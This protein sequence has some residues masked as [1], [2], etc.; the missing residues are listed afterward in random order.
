MI[1]V[2]DR[3]TANRGDDV[4]IGGATYE[5]IPDDGDGVYERDQDGPALYKISSP[6]GVAVLRGLPQQ[7]YWIVEEVAP[8]G[9]DLSAAVPYSPMLPTNAQNCFDAGSVTCYADPGGGGMAT[10]FF[11][12]TPIA[13]ASSTSNDYQSPAV[14][15]VT[16]LGVIIIGG[17]LGSVAL[18]R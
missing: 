13:S 11:I 9:Y 17:A 5:V 3:G 6:S 18:R 4:A 12:N 8:P 1:T 14:L 10:V 15:L 2:D 7:Q 16:I